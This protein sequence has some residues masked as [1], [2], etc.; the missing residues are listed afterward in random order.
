M[1]PALASVARLG[2]TLRQ[3]REAFLTVGGLAVGLAA[4]VF[5]S[6][7]SI[8]NWTLLTLG[9]DSGHPLWLV[10]FLLWT[11]G[12]GAMYAAVT[13]R[14]TGLDERPRPGGHLG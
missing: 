6:V 1:G 2:A 10:P 12:V 13:D 14:P 9:E 5:G 11:L 3:E 4:L 7:A 8:D